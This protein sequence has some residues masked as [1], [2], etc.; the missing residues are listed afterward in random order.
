MGCECRRRRSR[1]AR[2]R[3]RRTGC[4][5]GSC[6]RRAPRAPGRRRARSAPGLVAQLCGE[7]FL[8]V[9]VGAPAQELSPVTNPVAGDVV[10]RH[11]ANQLRPQSFP[12][13]LLIRFP[14]ARLARSPLAGAMR[15][16]QVDQLALLLRLEPGC[17]PND[18]ELAVVA[19]HAEDE[20]AH[21]ALLLAEPERGHDRVGGPDALDLDHADALARL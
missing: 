12:Y 17:V 21:R 13:E 8:R 11:L 18:V 9:L 1:R 20:R 16:E 10:E 4:R 7:A 15:L 2:R 6:R 5:A 19:V 14:A 3:C